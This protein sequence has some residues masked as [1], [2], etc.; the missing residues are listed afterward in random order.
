MRNNIPLGVLSVR[1]KPIKSKKGKRI[2][3]KTENEVISPFV[4][5][6]TNE[7]PGMGGPAPISRAYDPILTIP[8]SACEKGM[9]V[10]DADKVNQ[11]LDAKLN[12]RGYSWGRGDREIP[13]EFNGEREYWP[14]AHETG[15]LL[16]MGSTGRSLTNSNGTRYKGL[17]GQAQVQSE[18]VKELRKELHEI[19]VSHLPKEQVKVTWEEARES[20][21]GV[22]VFCEQEGFKMPEVVINLGLEEMRKLAYKQLVDRLKQKY[23]EAC[24]EECRET[25]V[26]VIVNNAFSKI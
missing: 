5:R 22:L 25:P 19:A 13:V 24:E 8:D 9:S 17:K 21:E 7:P 6:E 23:L 15:D 10:Y 20:G 16:G 1:T 18:Y 12:T 26:R 2:Q 3:R 11:R 14:D 4:P